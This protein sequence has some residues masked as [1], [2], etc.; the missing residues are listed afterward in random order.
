MPGTRAWPETPPPPTGLRSRTPVTND[1]CKSCCS[2]GDTV[3]SPLMECQA[4]AK[5]A[6]T[7]PPRAGAGGEACS[8]QPGRHTGVARQGSGF[9]RNAPVWPPNMDFDYGAGQ[10]CPDQAQTARQARRSREGAV[11][12]S[13]GLG[14]DAEEAGAA[15]DAS[16]E[17]ESD[18][19]QPGRHHRPRPRDCDLGRQGCG[20]SRD[21]AAR[22]PQTQSPRLRASPEG[23]GEG[24]GCP[25]GRCVTRPSPRPPAASA[26]PDGAHDPRSKQVPL[27]PQRTSRRRGVRLRHCRWEGRQP[28]PSPT[29][30]CAAASA[31]G[32]AGGAGASRTGHGPRHLRLLPHR[33]LLPGIRRQPPGRHAP[34]RRR[35][36][37]H[38][39]G[40]RQQ[41]ARQPPAGRCGQGRRPRGAEQ[42]L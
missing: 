16:T 35:R 31:A 40:G 18:L 34:G 37:G 41:K 24:P 32:P 14:D 36:P 25:P 38:G 30:A 21:P 26:S 8:A 11:W 15:A 12:P 19:R 28:L 3:T 23:P 4:A 22:A 1:K 29:S 42:A 7:Q 9:S 17:S 27:S 13:Q 6:D 20:L 33:R 39:F 5:C 10:P 2:S